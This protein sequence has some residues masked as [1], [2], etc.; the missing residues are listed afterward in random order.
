MEYITAK[1][2][3]FCFG[4]KRAMDKVYEQIETATDSKIYTYGPIIHNEEVVKQLESK[5]VVTIRDDSQLNAISETENK[6]VIIRSHG[7]SKRTQD[8]LADKGFEIVDA[9]C[10]FV[11]RIHNI[12]SQECENGKNIIII[13][14]KMHPEVEGIMGW[15]SEDPIVIESI[16]E[17]DEVKFE[18]SKKYITISSALMFVG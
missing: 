6:I 14:N 5:G 18:K 16:E 12:V 11:K 13:G 4:V 7:I 8:M 1:S 15:C 9:T 17:V 2:A 3:G 10:P